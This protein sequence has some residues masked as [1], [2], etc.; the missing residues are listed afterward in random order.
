[1][2]NGLFFLCLFSSVVFAVEDIQHFNTPQQKTL[3]LELTQQLRCLVCQNEALS[4]SQAVLARDLKDQI[5]D[6]VAR[7]E[8]KE[9]ILHYLT[10]RYGDFILYDPPLQ[11]NTYLL[12]FFPFS[13]LVI[14]V[15]VLILLIKKRS[16]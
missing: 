15:A 3:Y 13:M 9:K 2:K 1:M 11:K 8:N 6:R 4:D 10:V 14:G 5:R 16:S 7:G 12:W